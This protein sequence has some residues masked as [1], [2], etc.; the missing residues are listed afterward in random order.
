MSASDS[1]SFGGDG[2]AVLIT[3]ASSGIGAGS[4]LELDR[5]GYRVFAGVRSA[6]AAERLRQQ[7]SSRLTPVMLDVTDAASIA[8]AAA[9]VRA[10]VGDTGLAGLVNNAG[11]AICG[12]IEVLPLDQLRRQLEV[13][14]IGQIAVVQAV[15]P[16][17]RAARGR[18]INVGSLNG[19]VSPA[20]L[21]PYAASKYAMEALSDSLRMELRRWGIRVAI[22]EPGPIDTPIW[23]KSAVVAD[24][25]TAGVPPEPLA[26]YQDDLD[27][28]RRGVERFSADALPVERVVQAVVHALTAPRPK[29]RYF[30]TWM[31]RLSFKGF[32][33]LPDRFRD[34]LIRRQIGL[35]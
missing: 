34:W 13:N 2:P 17:L 14:V 30:I 4:A 11:I 9:T 31:V 18:I 21:G 12:P 33:M 19:T 24:Q 26:L 15:L 16:L 7:A 3:G 28:F 22:I 10:A 32:K 23:Q 35:P 5:R 1:A 29:I 27:A 25:I 6:D 20:F 8:A